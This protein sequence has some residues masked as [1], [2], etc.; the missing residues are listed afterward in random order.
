LLLC[1]AGK[2]TIAADIMEYVLDTFPNLDV[3]GIPA[4]SDVGEDAFQ[5]SYKKVLRDRNIPEVSLEDIYNCVDMVFLSLEFDKIVVPQKF[6]SNRLFNIHFSL[7]PQYRGM[8]TSAIPIINNESQTGVTLHYIDHGID[9]GDI[10]AQKAFRIDYDDTAKKLYSKYIH[11]GTELVKEHLE[12]IISRQVVSAVPQ[13]YIKATYYS[14]KSIDYRNLSLD[15]NQCAIAVYNQIR[16][17]N[18]REYQIPKINGIPIVASEVT[19]KRSLSKPGTIKKLDDHSLV[20]STIDY[21]V[22]LYVDRFNELMYAIE[23]GDLDYIKS[24]PRLHYYCNDTDQF[25]QTPWKRVCALG[26]PEWIDYFKERR[27]GE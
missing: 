16:A 2:N 3:V 20:L 18:F 10:I 11:F 23:K 21:D 9:T 8:Y 14:K 24:I 26:I 1:I 5:R 7:L 17:F 22:V 12:E 13:D 15:L 19:S 25:G 6:H 27:T 4:K